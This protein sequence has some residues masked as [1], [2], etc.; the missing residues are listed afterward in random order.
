MDVTLMWLSLAYSR[1]L[2][3]RNTVRHCFLDTL[4]DNVFVKMS[5]KHVCP[6]ALSI[7]GDLY[8]TKHVMN[9]KLNTL[10]RLCGFLW[11]ET[12]WI[13]TLWNACRGGKV[14]YSLVITSLAL[15]GTVIIWWH[16]IDITDRKIKFCSKHQRCC[17]FWTLCFPTPH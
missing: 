15:E 8:Y 12:S 7:P 1:K 13:C 9:I 2:N 14:W 6:S 5:V 3:T 10:N 4:F 16:H 11:C 17:S